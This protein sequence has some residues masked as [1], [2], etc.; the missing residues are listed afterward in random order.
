MP[1]TIPLNRHQSHIIRRSFFP[2][3]R[4]KNAEDLDAT[5]ETGSEIIGIHSAIR[6]VIKQIKSICFM[7][8][9]QA[10]Q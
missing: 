5:I 2:V 8:I 1:R 6:I 3:S 7:T 9:P 10:N 4:K